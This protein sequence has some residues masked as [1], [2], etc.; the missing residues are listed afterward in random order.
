MTR[1]ER[2]R[3]QVEL[4]AAAKAG[5][6]QIKQKLL[7]FSTDDELPPLDIRAQIAALKN[8][9]AQMRL[10]QR[11]REATAF[12]EAVAAAMPMAEKLFLQMSK[13]H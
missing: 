13:K 6:E 2:I 4:T 9:N 3:R 5:I 7:Q 1:D 11:N 12:S 8:E 10:A